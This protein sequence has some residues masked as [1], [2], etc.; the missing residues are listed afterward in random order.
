MPF[1]NIYLP[2]NYSRGLKE[3]ISYSVHESLIEI[4]SIPVNDYFQV[5]H[6]VSPENLIFPESYLDISHLSDLIYIQIICGSGR[7]VE[8]K[9]SLYAVIVQKISLRTHISANDIIIVLNETPFE[10]W[11]FGLGKAQMIK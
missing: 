10:N 11:S 4:F 7:T 2:E 5:I 6:P 9:K 3:K 1:V 8:M